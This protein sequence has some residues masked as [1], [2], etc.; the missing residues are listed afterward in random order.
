M[1]AVILES[2]A[3]P[4]EAVVCGPGGMEQNRRSTGLLAVNINVSGVAAFA[5]TMGQLA[6]KASID[7]AK[8]MRALSMTTSVSREQYDL[9]QAL[10]LERRQVGK[11]KPYRALLRFQWEMN[12]LAAQIQQEM[13]ACGEAVQRTINRVDA[14][15]RSWWALLCR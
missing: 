5:K 9:L 15:L 11:S 14:K 3:R 4:V 8:S 6:G 2:D 1:K 7:F 13:I 12:R 10:I